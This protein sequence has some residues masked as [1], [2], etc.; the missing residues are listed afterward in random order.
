[1]SHLVVHLCESELLKGVLED[2][3]AGNELLYDESSNGDHGKTAVVQLLCLQVLLCRWVAGEQTK[4]I[5]SKV[6]GLV[7]ISEGV[8]VGRVGSC[9]TQP[10]S[11]CL[12]ETDGE[13]QGQPENGTAGFD[14]L[15]VVD[16]RAGNVAVDIVKNGIIFKIFLDDK[17][18][19]SEHSHTAMRN[20]RLAPSP[21]LSDW[22]GA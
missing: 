17:S 21:Q 8:E 5:K 15:K 2:F 12:G 18:K 1:M 13:D 7:I 20:L 22:A 16:S 4:R 6:T 14:L 3:L 10:D 19:S 9:P 11:V